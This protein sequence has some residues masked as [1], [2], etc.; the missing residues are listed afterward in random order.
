MFERSEPS[1]V[2]REFISNKYLQLVLSPSSFLEIGW[3]QYS[4]IKAPFFIGSTAKRPSP[5]R[6]LLTETLD[7]GFSLLVI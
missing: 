7:G 4:I 2:L 3:P 1:I 6:D 5:D